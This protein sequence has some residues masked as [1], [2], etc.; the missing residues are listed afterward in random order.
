MDLQLKGRRILITG[1]SSGIGL[2]TARLL[3]EEGAHLALCA[4]D[5]S[6]LR[7]ATADLA[8]ITDVVTASCDVTE[9]ASVEDFVGRAV[10]ELGGLDGAVCNAG[11]SL[12]RTLDQTTDSEVRDEFDLKIFGALNVVRAA[13]KALA[14]SDAGSVVVVNAILSRQPELQLAITAAARAGLL[15]LSRSLAGDLAADGIRV[16]S[17][18]LGLVDTGQWQR[19]FED[20]GSDA[21]FQTWS[22]VIARDRGIALGRFG[23]ADELAFPITTLLSPRNSYMTGAA[24][25]VG[26]GVHRYV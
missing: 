7:E 25:D 26:G 15:N 1:A 16:N 19:R 14:A 6:R 3:A 23:T 22:A 20:S 8:A 24:L 4:R 17:V 2:A 11:R 12:M 13:R 9:R 5:E 21:D 18:L 10:D